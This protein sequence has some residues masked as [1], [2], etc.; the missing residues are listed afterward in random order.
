MVNGWL[1]S[2]K[3]LKMIEDKTY[4]VVEGEIYHYIPT[5]YR[6][7]DVGSFH[8]DNYKFTSETFYGFT[9]D[10][11]LGDTLLKN[12]YQ[13]KIHHDGNTILKIWF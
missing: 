10:L 11:Q 2:K 5:H 6:N 1:D 3:T 12:G 9:R 4:S 13:V 7:R 8:V